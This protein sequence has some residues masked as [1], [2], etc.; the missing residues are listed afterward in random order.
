M[1]TF[2]KGL[3]TLPVSLILLAYPAITKA[4]TITATSLTISGAVNFTTP[5]VDPVLL[6]SVLDGAGATT[7]GVAS[8]GSALPS[9]PLPFSVTIPAHGTIPA[10][11]VSGETTVMGLYGL[12]SSVM[13]VFNTALYNS[14]L[15][16]PGSV[17]YTT[18]FPSPNPSEAAL[19]AAIA[20]NGTPASQL[21]LENFF[22]ANSADWVPFTLSTTN[23]V[24][25]GVEF[26]AG[27][28]GGSFTIAAVTATVPEPS[29]LMLIGLGLPLFAGWRRLR[30]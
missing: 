2:Q 29:T 18:E 12:P 7:Y 20:S 6:Y 9:G 19:A 15:G 30:S 16:S 21:L 28:N 1:K 5:L 11:I 8:L 3:G 27:Q 25:G 26:S 22:A 24:T 10:G 4:S 17:A 13:M 14:I 23:Y